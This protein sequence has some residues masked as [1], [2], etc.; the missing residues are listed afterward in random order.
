MNP[1]TPN[2]HSRPRSG[3]HPLGGV[4]VSVREPPQP[5]F[6]RRRE[7]TGRGGVIVGA[8]TRVAL[9]S[10]ANPVRPEHSRRARPPAW[11]DR[12]VLSLAEG[13]TT[14]GVWAGNIPANCHSE[15]SE[16]SKTSAR[17]PTMCTSFPP[18]VVWYPFAL[19]IE[20][21][22][23]LPKGSP[24]TDARPR[25]W[26][27]VVTGKTE[28]IGG[29]T[30]RPSQRQIRNPLTCAEALRLLGEYQ[31]DSPGWNLP[32]LLCRARSLTAAPAA[33]YGGSS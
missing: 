20:P 32:I 6:P 12:P 25:P 4:L 2:R 3:I 18:G 24:R 26:M 11:F 30:L 27:P 10:P 5:S 28:G 17:K 1:L 15:R 21:A 23:G 31:R 7:P 14:S 13:L 22:L 9:A 29:A 19:S 8:T 33:R 16:E